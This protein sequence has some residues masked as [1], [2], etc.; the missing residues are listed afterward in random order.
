MADRLWSTLNVGKPKRPLGTMNAALMQWKPTNGGTMNKNAKRF[1][2]Y[3][4]G[5]YP[6][7]KTWWKDRNKL[8]H[9]IAKSF[10]GDG[11]D[12]PANDYMKTAM[13]TA[14]DGLDLVN[15]VMK[16]SRRQIRMARNNLSKGK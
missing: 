12:V 1:D 2:E 7:L 6:R 13:S 4:E 16:W 10:Q 9:G 15:A 3:M 14:I 5:L 11:P 8:L